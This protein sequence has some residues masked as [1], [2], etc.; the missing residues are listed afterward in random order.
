M[1]N[2]FEDSGNPIFVVLAFAAFFLLAGVFQGCSD[3]GDQ[4]T[5]PELFTYEADWPAELNVVLLDTFPDGVNDQVNLP[6]EQDGLP[7]SGPVDFPSVDV[8]QII[9]GVDRGFLYMRVDYRGSIPTEPVQIIQAGEVEAQ[10]VT[11]Q[12]M[13]ISLN[14]DNNLQTGSSGDGISG[15]DIFFAIGFTFGNDINIYANY[16]F[17]DGDI[18]HNQ[19]QIDGELGFGGPGYSY[20]IVR[21]D[22]S[23]L[24]S[25]FPLGE[26]IS[27][28]S[29]SEAESSNPDGTIKYHHFAFDP[30]DAVIWTIPAN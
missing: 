7:Y 25:F 9:L 30:F 12:G 6:I 16:D 29:W 26:T 15:V 2:G 19:Q 22:I 3:E 14:T 27:F 5:G 8:T 23:N 4:G 10:L 11:D 24:G 28:G 13:N 1:K 21:Y 18:H 17:P 20:A